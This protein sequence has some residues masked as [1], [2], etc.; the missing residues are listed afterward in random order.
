[1]RT[2]GEHANSAQKRLDLESNP[3]PSSCEATTLTTVSP[4]RSPSKDYIYNFSFNWSSQILVHGAV[5]LPIGHV[6]FLARISENIHASL[7]VGISG[8]RS[9]QSIGNFRAR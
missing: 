4:C 3:E 5:E 6:L 2:R 1:M 9:S 8:Q 7:P